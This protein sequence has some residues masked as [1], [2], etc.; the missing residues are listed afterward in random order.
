M[1]VKKEES[2]FNCDEDAQKL[3]QESRKRIDEIDN[4]IV[5]L[6]HDI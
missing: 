3:L 4:D 5:D 1:D 2:L 6:I